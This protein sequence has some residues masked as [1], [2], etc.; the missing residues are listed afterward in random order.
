MQPFYQKHYS[1]SP[2]YFLWCI[3]VDRLLRRMEQPI[4]EI[5]CGAGQLARF[6]C[7]KGVD[8][9][10]GTDFSVEAIAMARSSCP[11]YTFFVRD[12]CKPGALE[13]IPYKTVIAIEV[14]EHLEDDLGTLTQIRA[15][16]AVLGSVPS[17]PASCHVRHFSGCEEVTRRYKSLFEDFRVD[18]FALS[19]ALSSKRNWFFVFEG[20]RRGEM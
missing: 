15:G 18:S 14:L 20:V 11:R 9:Y 7:D 3:V 10:Y 4:L 8:S 6:L 17:F 19:D 16:T 12:L 1:N 13:G 5:G 2:Y